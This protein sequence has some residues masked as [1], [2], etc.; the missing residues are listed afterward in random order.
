MSQF[1][2]N[3]VTTLFHM[4]LARADAERNRS[5]FK[6]L[7]EEI[8]KHVKA[9]SSV[10][11]LKYLDERIHQQLLN[12]VQ[13]N[14]STIGLY[15]NNLD[16]LSIFNGFADFLDFEKVYT[17]I[18]SIIDQSISLEVL[19]VPHK[20]MVIYDEEE[21]DYIEVKCQQSVFAKQTLEWQFYPVSVNNGL[22]ENIGEQITDKHITIFFISANLDYKILFPKIQHAKNCFP[23]VLED[24]EMDSMSSEESSRILVE[25]QFYLFVQLIFSLLHTNGTDQQQNQQTL[26]EKQSTHIYNSGTVV[27][28]NIGEIKAEYISSRD[29]HININNPSKK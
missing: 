2:T 7:S 10:A 23:V 27:Q 26:A 20:F 13:N 19:H 28:G 17:N 4:A 22:I 6:K 1:N 5:G 9:D 16:D 24:V 21:T 14:E 3:Q 11:S 12:A 18:K 8:K 25:T 15:R 29:M